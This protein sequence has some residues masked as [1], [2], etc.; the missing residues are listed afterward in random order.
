MFLAFTSKLFL[1][2]ASSFGILVHR[3]L[4][5]IVCLEVHAS[6]FIDN[7]IML[8]IVFC[9]NLSAPKMS[10]VE[11]EIS[12]D[13]IL[14]IL[15][16]NKGCI[17]QELALEGQ[18]MLQLK[19]M[20]RFYSNFKELRFVAV[21]YLKCFWLFKNKINYWFWCKM[22]PTLFERIP[23]I[24]KHHCKTRMRWKKGSI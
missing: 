23:T 1:R 16:W 14:R 11:L 9:L 19:M 15:M 8:M 24:L 20:G 7:P 21:H 12:Q 17:L 4:G 22:F 18:I 5:A 10:Y 13:N 3:Y 6:E 2:E